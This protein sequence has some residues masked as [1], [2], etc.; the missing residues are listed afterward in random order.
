MLRNR[1]KPDLCLCAAA[2]QVIYAWSLHRHLYFCC[3]KRTHTVAQQLL[4]ELQS[5][6][7]HMCMDAINV[8]KITNVYEHTSFT[9]VLHMVRIDFICTYEKLSITNISMNA[10]TPTFHSADISWIKSSIRKTHF[11][12]FLCS[13][14]L[15]N[16]MWCL[17]I[18]LHVLY[19]HNAVAT[20]LV[21]DSRWPGLV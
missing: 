12:Q 7:P 13:K 6:I 21:L 3:R 1:V 2:T 17:G 16:T 14:N 4:V 18:V 9:Q 19:N 5:G 20:N 10:K 15:M 11:F 8:V